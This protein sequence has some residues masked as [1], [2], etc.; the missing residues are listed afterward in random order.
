MTPRCL[1]L[2]LLLC[3]V[4]AAA[5]TFRAAVVVGHNTGSGDRPPL[6]YAEADAGKVAGVLVELGGVKP[7]DLLLLQGRGL[8][9]VRRA[10]DV[11]GA[12]V[13]RWHQDPSARVVLTFYYSG[14]SDGV[15]LELGRERLP[16]SD[17][18]AWLEGTGAD[19]R[20]ALVDS[21]R[22]GSLL[23]PKGGAPGP[24]F[25]VRLADELD[26]SGQVLL[27]SSAADELAL[28][29]RELG[30]SF[31]THHLV[32]GLRGAADASNDGRVTLA[33]VY[34]YAFDRTVRDTSGTLIGAQHPSYDFR[35][36]G[37][38]ELV[39]TE[40]TRPSALLELPG[41]FRRA[42]VVSVARDQVVA[43]LVPGAARRLALAPGTYAVRLVRDNVTRTARVTVATGQVRTLAWNE[44]SVDPG[45]SPLT[46]AKGG[47]SAEP[48]TGSEAPPAWDVRVLAGAQGSVA[49]ELGALPGLRVA[50]RGT[51]ASGLGAAVTVA[52]GS[53][54]GVSETGAFGWLGY[55]RAWTL[56]AV[57]ASAGLELGAGAI[58]QRLD[59]SH[60]GWSGAG[61][62]AAW[63]GL[64]VPLTGPLSLAA[65]AQVP[66]VGYRR[67][68]GL[69]LAVVPGAWL[70]LSLAR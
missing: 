53:D 66:L 45:A 54:A 60:G 36:S 18:R 17:L 5:E 64:E 41:D 16:Y 23:A 22:S 30:G 70:G 62:V 61:G 43:E 55:R 14:H 10:L 35:L 56:D 33:E 12:K 4:P 19:V 27:T 67:A 63:A 50:L 65:E 42:L 58:F 25:D 52:T 13:R 21:C 20:V 32:S 40:L 24:S 57:R 34:Q 59:A 38:G 39:L 2:A 31:F 28:E 46:A 6:R 9:E 26:S 49:Q 8:A 47:P 7:E 48:G 68:N 51:E 44:L 11:A 29:S 3:A 69:A 37:R 15:A 1:A